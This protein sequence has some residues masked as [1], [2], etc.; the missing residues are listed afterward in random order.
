[1]CGE[2]EE[3][4]DGVLGHAGS[5]PHV[6]G[7]H[8]VTLLTVFC[9]GIIPACAGSTRALTAISHACRD[10]PRMCGE[11]GPRR[12]ANLW[13]PGSSPHVR[14]AHGRCRWCCE[15]SGIIPACAGSTL[16]EATAHLGAWDHPRM[17]GEHPLRYPASFC[18]RG[19]SPH[20]RGA[21][22]H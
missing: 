3:R 2:H 22:H 14:G 6:R 20:V 16:G 18:A 9:L 12:Y 5:S 13:R 1:M 7:A 11:H 10:H 15:H 4:S 19:S 8:G 17:C 21:R